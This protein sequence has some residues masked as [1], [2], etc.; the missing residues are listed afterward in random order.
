MGCDRSLLS[1]SCCSVVFSA[2]ILEAS[3][4]RMLWASFF[5]GCWP[6]VSGGDTQP[7]PGPLT[8]P[9]ALVTG[10]SGDEQALL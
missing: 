3:A 6:R 2:V 1:A 10:M 7:S 4:S 9:P 5:W 8:V